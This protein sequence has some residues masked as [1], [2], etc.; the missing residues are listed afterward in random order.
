MADDLPG[1]LPWRV[2]PGTRKE[3]MAFC[4]DL[5]PACQSSVTIE[6]VEAFMIQ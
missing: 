4:N 2:Q 3:C 5:Q 6:P 1:P